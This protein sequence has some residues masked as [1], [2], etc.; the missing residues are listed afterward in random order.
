MRE[1][2]SKTLNI[3]TLHTKENKFTASSFFLSFQRNGNYKPEK[4]SLN[5]S[6]SSATIVQN[7][8]HPPVQKRKDQT[9][10]CSYTPHPTILTYFGNNRATTFIIYFIPNQNS[11]FASATPPTLQFKKEKIKLSPVHIYAPPHHSYLFRE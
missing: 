3:K 10:I 11:V 8:P 1:P 9:F 5:L 2:S 4:L 6:R 7:T